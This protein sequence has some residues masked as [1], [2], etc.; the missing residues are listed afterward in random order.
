MSDTPGRNGNGHTSGF[1]LDQYPPLVAEPSMN[2]SQTPP[3]A[4]Q[5]E[6]SG[7]DVCELAEGA[8]PDL[9]FGDLSRDDEDWVRHHTLTCS[10]CAGVLR[11]FEDVCT[12][13][14]EC[15]DNICQEAVKKF[16]QAHIALGMPEARYG[17]AETP[18]GDVLIA[19]S[20]AGICEIS[21]LENHDRYESLR[22]I[23]RRGFLVY[24]KTAAVQPAIDQLKEYFG[25]ERKDFSLPLDLAGV[26][27]FTR[28]VLVATNAIPY[29]KVQ[30][31]GDVATAIG[32]PRASRAVGNALGRNPIPVII[33]CHRVILSSGA[34]GWY[35]GGPE[36]K[37]TLLGIEGVRYADTSSEIAST[38]LQLRM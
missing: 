18:V 20:D 33:P 6:Q 8:M 34:M 29:G 4:A 23:E 17:F 26:T 10:Y 28:D 38:P 9:V 2:H 35:T 32:K 19:A 15:N 14:D 3:L 1:N 16:P 27:P 24:E 36:I 11:S 37:R 12:S 22:E 25:H 7:A 30:T 21:Y 5:A 13:L 31:Y